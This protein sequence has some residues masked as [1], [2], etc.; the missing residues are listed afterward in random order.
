MTDS[1]R[2]AALEEWL[3]DRPQVIK[4][5]AKQCPPDCYRGADA[6]NGHYLLH[7]Y[8]EDGTVKVI[9]GKDSYAPG[10]LVFGMHPESLVLCGCGKWEGAS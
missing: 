7:A 5:L 2:V 6:P 10:I 8:S 9:H 1:E 3:K 4:D